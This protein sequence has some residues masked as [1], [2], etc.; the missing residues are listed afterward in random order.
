[1]VVPKEFFDLYPDPW[2]VPVAAHKYPPV[3][4]P[5]VAFNPTGN[6]TA[7]TP[8][9]DTYARQAR[10]AYMAAVS[11]MDSKV[12]DILQALDESGRANDTIVI[13]HADHGW[14]LGEHGEWR[15]MTNLICRVPLMV[16]VP[17]KNG[18]S[19]GKSTDQLVELVGIYPT[20]VELAGLLPPQDEHKL[21]GR[22]F[23]PLSTRRVAETSGHCRSTH[24]ARMRLPTPR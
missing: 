15:K 12:G 19:A 8:M 17:W 22:S 7:D 9:P 14:Q 13:F 4:M 23:A 1:M 5:P 18:T 2:Q 10:R 6:C 11:Y 16:R 20:L 24:A 21:E 3:G